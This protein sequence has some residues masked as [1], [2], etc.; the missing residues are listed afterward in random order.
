M[1]EDKT[2]DYQKL[3]LEIMKDYF[4]GIRT[5]GFPDFQ[6]NYRKNK[7]QAKDLELF[8]RLADYMENL[9]ELKSIYGVDTMFIDSSLSAIERQL[10]KEPIKEHSS[11]VQLAIENMNDRLSEFK[12]ERE[13]ETE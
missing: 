5:L 12:K 11:Q 9:T 1:N 10:K 4:L 13:H 3:C 7:Y 2:A 6:D 8:V